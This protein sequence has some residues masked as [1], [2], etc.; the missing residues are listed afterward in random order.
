ME[1]GTQHKYAFNILVDFKPSEEPIRPEARKLMTGRDPAAVCTGVLGIPVA[2]LLSEPI[3]I[4]QAPKL[5]MVL[6]EVDNQHRQIFADRRVLPKEVNLPAYLGYSVGRWER[7]TFVVE[8][9]GFNDK[10]ILDLAGHRHSEAL[11]LTERFHRRDFGHLDVEMTFDDPQVYTKPFAI[12]VS[13]DLMADTDLFEM[14]C[15]EN[16]RDGEHLQ[17]KR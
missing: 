3:K 15:N 14:P 9:A 13:F 6:Y 12:K 11:H 8:T 17:P 2:G 7:D 16:E 10:T 1:I 4:V 5:T